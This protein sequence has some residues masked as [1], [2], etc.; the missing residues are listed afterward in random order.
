MGIVVA[1]GMLE[2]GNGGKKRVES[3][4]GRMSAGGEWCQLNSW[5]KTR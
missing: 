4:E 2:M 5:T 1:D 3:P